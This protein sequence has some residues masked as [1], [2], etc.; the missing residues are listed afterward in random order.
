MFIKL[1]GQCPWLN[2]QVRCVLKILAAQQLKIVDIKNNVRMISAASRVGS[3]GHRV[4]VWYAVQQ[5]NAVY[6]S[7][8]ILPCSSK[9]AFLPGSWLP[10]LVNQP[11]NAWTR[12]CDE[13]RRRNK[14]MNEKARLISYMAWCCHLVGKECSEPCQK[15]FCVDCATPQTCDKHQLYKHF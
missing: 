10:F 5:E 14:K 6:L 13:G 1:L 15:D 7:V 3:A 12:W 8:V 9:A 11:Q 4:A 2:S